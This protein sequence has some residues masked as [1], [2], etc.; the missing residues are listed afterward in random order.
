[1]GASDAAYDYNS[2]KDS[3]PVT[4]GDYYQPCTVDRG[5]QRQCCA[6]GAYA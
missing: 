4:Q 2:Q 6:D 1:M 3:E 5:Y